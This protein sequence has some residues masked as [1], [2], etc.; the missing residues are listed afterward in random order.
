MADGPLPYILIIILI[1]F[2]AFF[3][4]AET[5]FSTCNRIRLKVMADDGSKPA[6]MACKIAEQFDKALITILIGNNLVNVFATTVATVIFVSTIKD[7]NVA[8]IVS[9]IVITAVVYIFGETIPKSIARARSLG[10]ALLFAHIIRGLMYLFLPLSLIFQAMNWIFRKV[11]N[12]KDTPI[13]TE[14]DFANIIESIEEEGLIEESESE[15]IQSALDFGETI[16]KDVLTPAGNIFAIDIDNIDHESLNE[17]INN[18]NYSR[19]PV[20]RKNLNNIVGIFHVKTYLREYFQNRKVSIKATLSK[21]Y[22]VS[23]KANVDEIFEGFRKL[24]THI[25]IVQDDEGK[26]LGM[27]TMEDLLEELVGEINEINVE[28]KKLKGVKK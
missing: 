20:Y 9:T 27:V 4:A 10:V 19:I 12:V 7:P 26:T 18:K 14:D 21:P 11:M 17:I 13:L 25:A 24:K 2:S 6:K 5:A 1:L 23:Y 8:S 15:I 3:S 22:L 16:V 28:T